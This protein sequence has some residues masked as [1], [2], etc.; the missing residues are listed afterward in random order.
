MYLYPYKNL[1]PFRTDASK[2]LTP[3]S[4]NKISLTLSQ[5]SVLSVTTITISVLSLTS[6][7]L[8]A[9]AQSVQGSRRPGSAVS[10]SSSVSWNGSV[11]RRRD[12]GSFKTA[13]SKLQHHPRQKQIFTSSFNI[14]LWRPSECLFWLLH[15]ENPLYQKQFSSSKPNCLP[16][17]FFRWKSLSNF[18]VCHWWICLTNNQQCICQVLWT[19]SH[20]RHASLWKPW[21]PLADHHEHHQHISYHWHC[22][23]WS[24]DSHRHTSVKKAITWQKSFEKLPSHF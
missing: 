12:D 14:W 23:T 16:W 20:S 1:K 11:G 15:W 21:H 9:V 3:A 10:R 4:L 22:T 24:E 17:Y 19:W 13:L 2:R 6:T 18:W 8:S 5:K 7:P